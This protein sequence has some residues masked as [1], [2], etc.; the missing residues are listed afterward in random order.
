[1]LVKSSHTHDVHSSAGQRG[2]AQTS[3]NAVGYCVA[4]ARHDSAHAVRRGVLGIASQTFS[5]LPYRLFFP[6]RPATTG[7][8]FPM[9]NVSAFRLPTTLLQ[10]HAAG[11]PPRRP[12]PWH[13]LSRGR[14]LGVLI[15][16]HALAQTVRSYLHIKSFI[17]GGID[18]CFASAPGRYEGRFL[19]S[20]IKRLHL[21]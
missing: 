18:G 17:I 14:T 9:H 8:K 3:V 11:H 1:M 2:A 5:L 10:S 12:R 13:S 20:G 21:F 16:C 15:T 4:A 19:V 6:V 7:H